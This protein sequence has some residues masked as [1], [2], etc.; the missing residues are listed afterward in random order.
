MCF[1]DLSRR[2]ESIL[3]RS[4]GKTAGEH[5]EM[6]EG[7]RRAVAGSP[8]MLTRRCAAAESSDYAADEGSAAIFPP[9]DSAIVW[10]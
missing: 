7:T 10:R 8:Q 5:G 6:R 2:R 4:R 3:A 9:A 1:D